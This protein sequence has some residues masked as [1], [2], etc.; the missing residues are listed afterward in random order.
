LD[1]R[2]AVNTAVFEGWTE[3][4]L[5]VLCKAT[6]DPGFIERRV[7]GVVETC[8]KLKCY[9]KTYVGAAKVLDEGGFQNNSMTLEDVI[10]GWSGG[11]DPILF[12]LMMKGRVDTMSG[13]ILRQKNTIDIWKGEALKHKEKA[14]D[15][16]R[17]LRYAKK[18]VV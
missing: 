11:V 3:T 2:V 1:P 5:T 6:D 4:E 13:T 18:G 12:T 16:A 7:F 10:Q 17:R 15:L 9:V 8:K 14:E